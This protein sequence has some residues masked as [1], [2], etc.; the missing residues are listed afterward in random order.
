M[1]TISLTD[2][3]AQS[4]ADLMDRECRMNGLQSAAT[5]GPIA[6]KIVEAAQ[7]ARET[8]KEADNG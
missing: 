6:R 7:A 4:I 2:G 3:E 8:E 5:Y 1:I